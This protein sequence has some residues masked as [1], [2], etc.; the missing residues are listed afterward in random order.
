[1]GRSLKLKVIAEGVE[2]QAQLEWLQSA[3]CD[4]IQGFVLGRP[5]PSNAIHDFLA[6]AGAPV[7]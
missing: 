5:M 7:R 4:E 3:R 2:N 1:L 6:E